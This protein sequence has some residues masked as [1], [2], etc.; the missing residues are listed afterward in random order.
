[1]KKEIHCEYCG[2][3]TTKRLVAT[4]SKLDR[5]RLVISVEAKELKKPI[6]DNQFY[7]YIRRGE[8]FQFC[9]AKCLTKY[10]GYFDKEVINA[11]GK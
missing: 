11:K 5:G 6:A 1:M 7:F 10:M 3:A 4:A 8:E 9:S 2:K